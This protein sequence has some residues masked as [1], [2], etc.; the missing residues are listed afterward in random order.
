MCLAIQEIGNSKNEVGMQYDNHPFVND[1][2][3]NFFALTF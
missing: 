2:T 1:D 3:P